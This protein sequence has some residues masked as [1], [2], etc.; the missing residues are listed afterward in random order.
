MLQFH[1]RLRGGAWRARPR[2][3]RR[4]RAHYRELD[5]KN[6]RTR[7]VNLCPESLGSVKLPGQR[8]Q[9]VEVRSPI[10]VFPYTLAVAQV[11]SG[12]EPP[13]FDRR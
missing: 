7:A 1:G 9:Q 11:V 13:E 5:P 12:G 8:H 10:P 3:T 4:G 2:R 6:S